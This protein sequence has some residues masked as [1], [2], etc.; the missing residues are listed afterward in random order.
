MNQQTTHGRAGAADLAGPLIEMVR[1]R[2][3]AL[4][5]TDDNGPRIYFDNPAGTQVPD[6]VIDRVTAYY[7]ETNANYGGRF[8][9]SRATVELARQ[10][11][12]GMAAFV[13]ARAADEIIIGPNMT[14]LTY[15]VARVLASS[16]RPGDEI[17]LTRMDHD[18]NVTPWVQLARRH[19]LV[20][21][22]LDFDPHTYRYDLTALESLVTERTVLAAFNYAS[23]ITGTIN[24]VAAIVA[25]VKAASNALCYVDAVQFAP[26]GAIDVQQ[27][28][29]DFLVCSAYKFYGPHVGVLWGRLDLLEQLQPDKLRAAPNAVPHRF[30]TGC[31]NSEGIAGLLGA[32]EYYRWLGD[33]LAGNSE[34]VNGTGCS[35]RRAITA[36][37]AWMCDH[38][39]ALAGRL[40]HGLDS[41]P[42]ITVHGLT[43]DADL[44]ERVSTISITVEGR[45]PATLAEALG[46]RNVFTWSGHNYAVD[47]IDTLGCA[48]NGGV[49]R[50][51]PVH[52]NTIEEVDDVI[53]LM[54]DLVT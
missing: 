32:I 39:R 43:D 20:I 6:L 49:L 50:F 44:D 26:H 3:P 24:D 38:E 51:G 34:G 22:W 31:A 16:F 12:E 52:Y 48:D 47:V 15:A 23:N 46:E 11:R 10:A 19:G 2:F 40:I 4:A 28:G 7:R 25:G 54:H 9:T 29:C 30:E 42:G 17:L 18:A 27:L 53:R 41:L 5:V 37:K 45:D 21:R 36:A 14:S 33:T 13:N 1:G 8:R 35:L